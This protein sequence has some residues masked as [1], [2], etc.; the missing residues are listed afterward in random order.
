MDEC[1]SK[2]YLCKLPEVSD[3]GKE[4]NLKTEKGIEWFML[5]MRDGEL[6]A[7]RNVCP[8]QGRS[9]NWAPDK[10]LFSKSGHLVC[11]HHGA[12]FDLSDGVCVDGPCKGAAL[13]AVPVIIEDEQ[14][15]LSRSD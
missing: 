9:M 2:N 11:C 13:T 7:W 3:T 12:S 8:H 4:V 6:T 15:F 5:F 10:F 14:V 1:N